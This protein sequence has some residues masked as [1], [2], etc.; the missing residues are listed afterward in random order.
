MIIELRAENVKRLKA[1][2]VTTNGE[3]GLV[4]VGGNNGQGKSSLLDAISLA[5]R[6]LRGS[7]TPRPIRQGE[8]S[9]EV[10]LRLPDLTVTRRWRIKADG[11]TGS[12][13]TVETAD[14]AKVS[15]PQALLDSLTSAIAYDPMSFLRLDPARQAAQL[16]QLV[17]I[18]TE[19]LDAAYTDAFNE[20]RDV[21][22]D[23]RASESR[24]AAFP[25]ADTLPDSP[26]D[27][28][29]IMAQMRQ[30]TE[31]NESAI[32]AE[33]AIHGVKARMEANNETCQKICHQIEGLQQQLDE[34]RAMRERDAAELQTLVDAGIPERVDVEQFR[35]M[36][37]TANDHNARY[38]VRQ[39][40]DAEAEAFAALDG[41]YKEL[42]RRL[43]EITR[44]KARI[45]RE[46][47]YPVDGLELTAAGITL[48]G[49]PLSQAS[50]AEQL[51]ASIAIGLAS[52]PGIRV[53]TAKD[54]SL[55]DPNSLAV[56]EA[57]AK[58]LNGQ[59]WLER[60]GK[61]QTAA[62]II[63]D[64]QAEGGEPCE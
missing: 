22:R 21:G 52:N 27:T 38:Q 55:L 53:I 28:R 24:L 32:R 61:D 42:D 63:E 19:A 7:E 33:N 15:S 1:V 44:E 4:V 59:V 57:T 54:G 60:V 11:G 37:E 46:A 64:G 45:T 48:N 58:E 62:V 50:G 39:N 5:L 16:R 8:E 13:L 17:G 36:I 56:L 12:T 18:D 40:R 41:T 3:P 23:R 43:S 10:L 47:K 35:Q 29:D 31:Q 34:M 9:A 30:A 25:Q 49:L 6:G 14:G 2:H 51:R 26:V 20:R